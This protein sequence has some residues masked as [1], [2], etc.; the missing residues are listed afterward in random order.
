MKS[1]ERLKYTMENINFLIQ[2]HY[3][4]TLTLHHP[5]FLSMVY[6]LPVLFRMNLK[7]NEKIVFTNKSLISHKSMIYKPHS[8]KRVF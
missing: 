7:G 3:T 1:L 2:E 6:T 8:A 5:S 4:P